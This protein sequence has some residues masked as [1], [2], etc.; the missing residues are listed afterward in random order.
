[1]FAYL[2]LIL[3]LIGI[4]VVFSCEETWGFLLIAAGA[5]VALY[6]LKK[7]NGKIDLPKVPEFGAN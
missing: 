6:A 3:F 2:A 5:G 7:N 4:I 1:M